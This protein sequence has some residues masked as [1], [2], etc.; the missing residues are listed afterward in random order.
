[1]KIHCIEGLGCFHFRPLTKAVQSLNLGV[2]VVPYPWTVKAIPLGSNDILCGHSFGGGKAIEIAN[3][4]DVPYLFL[5]LLD[6]RKGPLGFYDPKFKNNYPFDVEVYN[7]YQTNFVRGYPIEGAE[8]HL[9][10]GFSHYRM[11][12]NPAFL[13]KL[14]EVVKSG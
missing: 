4:T 3:K 13:F 11:P 6:P 10:K 1:M 7:Y 9:I 5:F 12:R 14:M 2:E 8:N